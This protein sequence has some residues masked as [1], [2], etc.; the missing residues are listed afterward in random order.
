MMKIYIMEY[1]YEKQKGAH[2]FYDLGNGIQSLVFN[3]LD[4]LSI[5]C[6][7]RLN[8][9]IN[10]EE[11][12]LPAEKDRIGKN[13]VVADIDGLQ[14][15]KVITKNNSV[16]GPFMLESGVLVEISPQ[17]I[18]NYEESKNTLIRMGREVGIEFEIIPAYAPSKEMRFVAVSSQRK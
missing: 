4:E 15:G 18:T 12:S 7:F 10:S 8:E 13:Y 16:M 6:G 14:K 3:N 5:N 2:I 9:M 1:I 11:L 17:Y